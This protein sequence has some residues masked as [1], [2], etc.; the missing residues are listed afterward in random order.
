MKADTTLVIV[1]GL[2]GSGKTTLAR[3]LEASLPALRISADD[4]MDGLSINLHAEEQRA[5][6]E[7]LQWQ[8]T[9]RLLTLGQSVIVEW[10]TWGKWERD[11]LRTEARA[12]GARVELHYLS[13]PPE[14]LF[15]R[16]QQRSREDPPIKW[17]DV[18]KWSQIFE[19]PTPAE[20]ALYDLPPHDF[21]HAYS[22]HHTDSLR[23]RAFTPGDLDVIQDIRK[24]AFKRIHTSFRNLLGETIFNMQYP[25]ADQKQ[26]DELRSICEDQSSNEVYVLLDG[27][28]SI[29]FVSVSVEEDRNKGEINLNAVDPEFQ[30]RGGGE[31]MYTFAVARLREKGVRLVGVGTGLDAAHEP[32]RRAYEKAG[33]LVGIPYIALFQLL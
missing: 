24:R 11:I 6:I 5:K 21:S 22:E 12:L 16:I 3:Q 25:D 17:E 10:G 13:A 28:R 27:G 2:P 33:F 26:A 14:E 15:A 29:G 9:K 1:C 8:L 18:H 19:P 23:I 20:M 4:W 31:K 32:A 30:G 7:T